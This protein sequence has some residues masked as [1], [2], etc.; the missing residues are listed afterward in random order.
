MYQQPS[1]KEPVGIVLDRAIGL[2]KAAFAPVLLLAFA[3]ALVRSLPSLYPSFSEVLQSSGVLSGAAVDVENLFGAFGRWLLGLAVTWPV[4]MFLGLAVIIQL[5]AVASGGR[6]AWY[7]AVRRAWQRILPML[8]CLAVF[9]ATVVLIAGG[10]VFVGGVVVG[11]FLSDVPAA[12]VGLVAG[13]IGM[14][15][16]LVAAIPLVVVFVYWCLALPLVATADVGAIAA[17][18]G[19]WRLVRGNWWR[20]LVIVSVVGFVVFAVTTLVQIVDMVLI[21]VTEGVLAL[22]V[23]MVLL[24][25]AGGTV[26]TT[27]F[28]AALLAMLR[29][30][31]PRREFEC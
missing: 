21:A 27:L 5:D 16:A 12:T 17:L 7:A 10:T 25:A 6:V 20:T 2:F 22:R 1:A 9:A 28:L 11:S 19:S 4:G 24:H 14:A 31:S 13:L 30:L 3:S 15:V 8:G 23:A 29:D 26:T 18:G